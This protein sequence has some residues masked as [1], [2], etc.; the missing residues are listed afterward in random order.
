[1]KTRHHRNKYPKFKKNSFSRRSS[2][3]RTVYTVSY[4]NDIGERFYFQV[5]FPMI[6]SRDEIASRLRFER[7]MFW[8][9]VNEKW[10]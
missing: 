10:S 1:M 3:G 6:V 5:T 4:G 7:K 9:Y 8:R 2:Y